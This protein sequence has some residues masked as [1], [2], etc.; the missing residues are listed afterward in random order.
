MESR[1]VHAVPFPLYGLLYY[2]KVGVLRSIHSTV[3]SFG[4]EYNIIRTSLA[5]NFGIRTTDPTMLSVRGTFVFADFCK[6]RE[7][8]SDDG[9][10]SHVSL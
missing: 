5:L 10:N 7:A 2:S 3:Y 1:Y 4:S 6:L 8:S 9:V